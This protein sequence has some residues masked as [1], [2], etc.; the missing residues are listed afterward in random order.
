MADWL[1]HYCAHTGEGQSGGQVKVTELTWE[2]SLTDGP[3]AAV[4]KG[5]TGDNSNRVYTL[6][7]LQ[8]V[9]ESVMVGWAQ[10]AID[11]EAA[12]TGSKTVAEIEAYLDELM[13]IAKDP[14]EGGVVPA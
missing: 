9:P 4:Q 12:A 14:A 1:V 6:P 5:T 2:A 7:A 3:V 13:A 10:Q 8:A 11:E